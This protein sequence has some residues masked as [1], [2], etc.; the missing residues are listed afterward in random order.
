[1]FNDSLSIDVPSKSC[2]PPGPECHVLR[3]V[4]LGRRFANIFCQCVLDWIARQIVFMLF[5]FSNK[6]VLDTPCWLPAKCGSLTSSIFCTISY[7]VFML[8]LRTTFR[9]CHKGCSHLH[10]LCPECEGRLHT[11]CIHN[12]S[13]SD[14]W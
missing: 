5:H 12:P 9:T 13:G 1:M 2:V 11:A 8:L 14:D 4:L 10:T 7:C 6:F 3:F